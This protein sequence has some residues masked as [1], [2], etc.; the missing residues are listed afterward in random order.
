MCYFMHLKM[1]FGAE[2]SLGFQMPKVD[3]T[4]K[5][6]RA[7]AGWFDTSGCGPRRPVRGDPASRLGGAGEKWVFEGPSG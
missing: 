1:F 4:A 6:W 2:V 7:A 5:L 3:H